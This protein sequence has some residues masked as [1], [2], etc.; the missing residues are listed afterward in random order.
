M[1]ELIAEVDRL[2]SIRSTGGFRKGADIDSF[3][4]DMW[5]LKI[6]IM[7]DMQFGEIDVAEY[8]RDINTLC[9][10]YGIFSSC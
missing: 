4:R 9:S 2:I 1:D 7:T 8:G 3:I 6:E 5:A 10:L